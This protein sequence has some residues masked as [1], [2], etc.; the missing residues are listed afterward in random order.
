MLP[1]KPLSSIFIAYFKEG[2]EFYNPLFQRIIRMLKRHPIDFLLYDYGS[3]FE[4]VLK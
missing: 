1:S 2:I 3:P 4:L